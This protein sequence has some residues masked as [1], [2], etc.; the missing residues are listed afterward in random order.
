M[1][2]RHRIGVISDT[3]AVARLVLRGGEL[4]AEIVELAV[5]KR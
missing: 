2:N 3:H 4:D 5:S 1:S